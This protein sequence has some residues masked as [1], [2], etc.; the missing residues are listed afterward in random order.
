MHDLTPVASLS[1]VDTAYSA[2]SVEWCPGRPTLFA[3]GTYQIEKDAV[4]PPTEAEGEADEVADKL[5]AATLKEDRNRE[6]DSDE[7]EEDGG[8]GEKAAAGPGFK[9]YGRCLLYEVDRD[10]RNV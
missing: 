1:T 2:D 8:D 9:R 3:V 4:E 5:A 7:D 10:G 6:G